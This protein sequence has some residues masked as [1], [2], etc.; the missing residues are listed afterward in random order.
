MGLDIS[1]SSGKSF[2]HASQEGR[3]TRVTNN[4]PGY[5]WLIEIEHGGGFSTLYAH[6]YENYVGVGDHVFKGSMI[7]IVGQTGNA[8]GQPS[9]EAHVHFEVRLQGR[10]YNPAT[11]LNTPCSW[12]LSNNLPKN[13][14]VIVP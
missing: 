3:V 4:A 6:N 13:W 9:T 12:S 10:Q 5:G 1:G 7:A 11:Y 8:N 14:P 2:I